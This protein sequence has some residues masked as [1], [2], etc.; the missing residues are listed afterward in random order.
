MEDLYC[1]VSDCI[2]EVVKICFSNEIVLSLTSSHKYYSKYIYDLT[3]FYLDDRYKFDRMKQFK[4]LKHFCIRNIFSQKLGI[5]DFNNRLFQR[6]TSMKYLK[7]IDLLK[8]ENL[9][10]LTFLNDLHIDCQALFRGPMDRNFFHA[11]HM[12]YLLSNI[13]LVHMTR[14]T[15]LNYNVPLFE[16]IS[17][18]KHVKNLTCIFHIFPNELFQF[19]NFSKLENLCI[20]FHQFSKIKNIVLNYLNLKTLTLKCIHSDDFPIVNVYKL[21]KL[22]YLHTNKINIFNNINHL[23]NIRTCILINPNKDYQENKD[24]KTPVFRFQRLIHLN[25]LHVEN[26][27]EIIIHNMPK[28]TKLKVNNVEYVILNESVKLL[29]YVSFKGCDIQG[30]MYQK[31]IK[32]VKA[33]KSGHRI[34]RYSNKEYIQKMSSIGK[35]KYVNY[36]ILKKFMDQ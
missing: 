26:A 19:E 27:F 32:Y 31:N 21:T 23:W 20:T 7:I 10:T 22:R 14:L 17:S 1:L 33:R 2:Y 12:Y 3:F 16:N 5:I 25:H 24:L 18:L 6:L 15:S 13:N 4:S 30:M 29:E 35:F 36:D 11:F 8:F 28:L 34:L 9:Q